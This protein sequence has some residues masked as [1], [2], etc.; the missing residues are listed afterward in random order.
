MLYV[1][2]SGALRA[3]CLAAVSCGTSQVTTKGCCTYTTS[4]DVQKRAV[5]KD[6]VANSESSE[7]RNDSS[8]VILLESREKRY[9][10]MISNK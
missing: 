1:H 2:G 8:A 9:M 7:L 5:K 4:F 10:K 6:T 3:L